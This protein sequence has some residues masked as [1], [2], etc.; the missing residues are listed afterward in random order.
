VSL[1]NSSGTAWAS[2]IRKQLQQGK[3]YPIEVI[4]A[5]TIS[6][7]SFVLAATMYDTDKTDAMTSDAR[8]ERQQVKI[9]STATSESQQVSFLNWTE[10][11]QAVV[12]VKE[13]Q[14]VRLTNITSG[15]PALFRLSVC[16]A[17]T[18]KV[19]V[20]ALKCSLLGI[21]SK[22]HPRCRQPCPSH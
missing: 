11:A 2:S 9:T 10:A 5:A 13:V 17:L 1:I 3:A 22:Q 18:G 16:N 20:G 14:V 12:P 8:N 19:S 4:Q 15:A 6:A 7:N 21:P